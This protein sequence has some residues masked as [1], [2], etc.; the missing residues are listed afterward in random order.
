MYTV[1]MQK[2]CSCFKKSEYPSEKAFETQKDAYNY[3]HVL[4]E[5]MNEDFCSI[6]MFSAQKIAGNDFLITVEDN[7]N[8]GCGT[9]SNSSCST[10]S[11]GC[12]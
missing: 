7:P 6:H 10:G 8:S 4:A 1:Y 2:E 11:C 3:A 5:L 12:E 9:G